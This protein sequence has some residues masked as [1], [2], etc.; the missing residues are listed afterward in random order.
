MTEIMTHDP[1]HDSFYLPAIFWMIIDKPEFQRLRN[2]KQTAN[3]HRVYFGAEHTRFGHSLGVAHL[4]YEYAKNIM[5][6]TGHLTEWDTILIGVA[7]LVH[8]IGHTAYSHLFDQHVVP[9]FDPGSDFTHESA[10]LD[11]FIMMYQKYKDINE[12]FSDEDVMT[13]GKLIFGD[14]KSTP[15]KFKSEITWYDHEKNY[16]YY[17]IVANKKNGVDVDKFDYLKRDSYYTGVETT[18]QPSRIFNHYRIIEKDGV[19][20][21][22]YTD[23]AQDIIDIMWKSR[24]NLHRMVY[25]HRVVKALDMMIIEIIKLCK[26]VIIPG[27]SVAL[28]DAH[29][30]IDAYC[31]ITDYTICEMAKQV[32][33]AELIMDRINKR[34]IWKTVATIK[35][36]QTL[37]DGF[38][39]KDQSVIYT[40]VYLKDIHI[41]Y[42]YTKD[43]IT[44]EI[45]FYKDL[46]LFANGGS[47]RLRK[48]DE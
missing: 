41:Y 31:K 12:T 39:F 6:K 27:T 43:R 28:K 38:R 47:I 21:M 20:T 16:F 2:I 10:S 1:I 42:V 25:Q 34:K 13:I 29:K 40:G 8:D 7:G 44:D 30:N 14:E 36:Q 3:T 19:L 35:T 26:D 45:N 37:N 15:K 46:I 5:E 18:F 11:I 17:E 23:K 9:Y 48:I 33:E 4:A 22:D 24:D 32:P